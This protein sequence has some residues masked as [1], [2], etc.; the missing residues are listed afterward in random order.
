MPVRTAGSKADGEGLTVIWEGDM[1]EDRIHRT[2]SD[3]GTELAGRIRGDGPPLVLV[4]GACADETEWDAAVPLLAERFTCYTMNTRCR[5]RSGYSD[6]L[7]PERLVEDVTAFADSIDAPVRLAGVSGGGMYALGAAARAESVT[8]VATW[9]PPV[10]EVVPEELA[11]SFQGVLERMGE[12]HAAGEHVDGVRT[13]LS[14][15]GNDHE[16]AALEA[17]GELA[18]ASRYLP[19]DLQEIEQALTAEDTSPTDPAVLATVSAPVLV[20]HGTASRLGSWFRTGAEFAAEHLPNARVQAV[21]GVGH[22]SCQVTPEPIM[23]EL[24]DFFASTPAPA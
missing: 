13:F 21:P 7:S 16:M 4:H 24:G 3:D 22:L 18:Y 2:V 6:D 15:V 9:E 14:F 17:A 19:V 23:R 20:L 12:Q 11:T 8:A 5:G 1:S 10:F